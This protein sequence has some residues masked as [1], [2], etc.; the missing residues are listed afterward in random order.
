MNQ[1]EHLKTQKIGFLG[2]GNMG[3]SI[4][5]GLLE[6]GYSADNIYASTRTE[7]KLQKLKSA[8]GI[9]VRN[10]NEELVEECN[11]IVL[12]VKPQDMYEV[13]EPLRASFSSEQVI[14]SLAAGISL[15]TLKKWLPNMT[16]I[17]RVMPNTAIKIK[18]AIV[19]YT[20]LNENENLDHIAETLFSPVA[21]VIK[22]EEGEAFQALTVGCSSGIGFIFELMMYWQDWLI[23]YGFSEAEAKQMTV[24]TFKGASLL[25]ETQNNSKLEELQS[26]VTSKK[27]VTH[28]GLTAMREFEIEGL[29]RM[30]FERAAIRDKQLGEQSEPTRP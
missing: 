4:I 26:K 17:I 16:Q 13:V 19:G 9:N 15:Y 30:S 7:S 27:G 21:K 25:A 29:L 18:E 11:I 2:A 28:A 3:E 22:T 5:K 10:N 23:G 20:T 6:G 1:L 14:I 12:G 24:Q 8:Y